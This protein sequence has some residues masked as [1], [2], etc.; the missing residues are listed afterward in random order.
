MHAEHGQQHTKQE[1]KLCAPVMRKGRI[2]SR[3]WRRAA[4]V[5]WRTAQ[6]STK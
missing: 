5:S 3:S 4:V 2:R 1:E 6:R